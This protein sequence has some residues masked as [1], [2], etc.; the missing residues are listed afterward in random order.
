[1]GTLCFTRS[2]FVSKII[3]T[4]SV[5]RPSK[6]NSALDGL[7]KT[8]HNSTALA[9]TFFKVSIGSQLSKPKKF[10]PKVSYELSAYSKISTTSIILS[11]NEPLKPLEKNKT[12]YCWNCGADFCEENNE[13]QLDNLL[14]CSKCSVLRRPP[15]HINHFELFGLERKFKMDLKKLAQKYKSMQRILHPDR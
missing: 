8:L 1:M 2:Q 9:P 10:L 15:K 6:T 5:V 7:K 3:A 4:V 12:N 14:T 11:F 13:N